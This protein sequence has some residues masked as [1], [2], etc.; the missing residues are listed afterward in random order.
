MPEFVLEDRD[1]IEFRELPDFVQGYIECIFF[2]NASCIPMSEFWTA[3]SQERIR[4]GQADGDLPSDA[5]FLDLDKDSLARIIADCE[6]FQRDA[7]DLLA[8]AYATEEY[9]EAQA[10]RDFWFTRCGHGV[11]FWCRDGID[12]RSLQEGDGGDS[13]GDQLSEIA[14]K[15]GERWVTFY[16]DESSHT[17]YG[18]VE[19]R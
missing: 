16:E 2:T 5:G 11:G 8:Q 13:I 7:A 17:G 6:A 12:Y 14:R 19:V 18:S 4:E 1:S 9:D 15:A 10:G 3:E